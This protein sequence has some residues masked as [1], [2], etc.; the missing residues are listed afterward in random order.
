MNVIN[1]TAFEEKENEVGYHDLYF[2]DHNR[3]VRDQKVSP[4]L[5][6][7]IK[8]NE[9]NLAR[10]WSMCTARPSPLSLPRPANN[11]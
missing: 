11:N 1:K 4:S 7:E 10:A 3:Q 5:E 2:Y 8:V 6:V 9:D